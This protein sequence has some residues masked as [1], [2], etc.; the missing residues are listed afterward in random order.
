MGVQSEAYPS[1]SSEGKYLRIIML[2]ISSLMMLIGFVIMSFGVFL[3][4]SKWDLIAGVVL[5]GSIISI[6]F[7]I[8]LISSLG[9][10][11]AYNRSKVSLFLY[12][13]LV[14]LIA[15][16]QITFLSMIEA[17]TINV[18]KFLG[19]RWLEMDNDSR[20]T[21]QDNFDC[22]G[23]YE[24]GKDSAYPCPNDVYMGCREKI[25]K[26]VDDFMLE[27]QLAAGIAIVLEIVIYVLGCCLLRKLPGKSN[28]L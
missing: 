3:Y 4:I 28:E 17:K 13:C 5:L 12:C 15:L 2:I 14:L 10:C 9:F 8:F 20:L 23:W 25:E 19:Y 16:G 1:P 7:L 21:I 18:Y 27:I 26:N 6:G 11:G 22:C 24:Y